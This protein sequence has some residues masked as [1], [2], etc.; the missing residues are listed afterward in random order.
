[1]PTTHLGIRSQSVQ[2]SH[3]YGGRLM[4]YGGSIA[5]DDGF[6]L[7]ELMIVLAIIGVLLLMAVASYVPASAAAAASACQH[8]QRALEEAASVLATADPPEE[9]SDLA[10]LV[11]NWDRVRVCPEDGTELAFNPATL[12]VSCPNHP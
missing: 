6:T 5:R 1:M 8:N 12:S 10:P 4:S 11:G 9:L 3:G 7:S 2:H